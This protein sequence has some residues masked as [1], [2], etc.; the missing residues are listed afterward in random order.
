MED[1]EGILNE[2]YGF[3][4][5][6]YST[7]EIDINQV[8]ENLKYIEKTL[9]PEDSEALNGFISHKEIRK[10]ISG[11]KN[12]KSLWEDGFLINSMINIITSLRTTF[13]NYIITYCCQRSNHSYKKTS[14]SNFLSRREIIVN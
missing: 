13:R 2:I 10:A 9:S 3:Y 4:T 14:W 6:L 7:G 8:N 1:K 12:E 11:M 5:N